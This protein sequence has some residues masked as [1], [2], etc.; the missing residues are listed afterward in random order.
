MDSL[1]GSPQI[2]NIIPSKFLGT[3][4]YAA[5][6]LGILVAIVMFV[7]GMLWLLYRAKRARAT[8]EGYGNHTL[9][10]P[11][12]SGLKLPSWQISMLPLIA[13]LVIN[14]I[15]NKI[16]V[17][18][19]D[20]LNPIIDMKLPLAASSVKTVISTWSLLIAVA[21]GIVIAGSVGFFNMPKGAMGKAINLGAVGSLLAIM[22]V[23]SE[24]GYG[25]VISALPGFKSIIA[26]VT[27]MHIGR[28]NP[29]ASMAVTINIICG[30]TGSASGGVSIALDLFSKTWMDW[31]AAVH[32]SPEILHR[33]ASIASGGFDTGTHNGAIITLLAV[34]GLTHKQSYPDIFVMTLLKILMVG[35]ALVAVSVFGIA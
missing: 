30:I 33:F 13:V 21:V 23:A 2:Q 31:A 16:V 5:P 24:V 32:M 17:W 12:L 4:I 7:T 10:E 22:N 29:L 1:P 34:C 15:G 8:G 6:Y 3:T 9:N 27:A 28:N 20:I 18:N 19:P 25:N 11:D 35:V 26:G 14:Y